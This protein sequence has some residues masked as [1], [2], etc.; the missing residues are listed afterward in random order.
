MDLKRL[1]ELAVEALEAQK[2]VVETEIEAIR[3]ELK[4]AETPSGAGSFSTAVAGRGRRNSAMREAQSERMRKIWAA[5]KAS[6]AKKST[7]PKAKPNRSAVSKAI[8]AAMKA[9][10][11]RRK[12]KAAVSASKAKRA[13]A[14]ALKP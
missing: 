2:A 8:S 12:A 13:S 6:A 9:A 14:K 5:R 3:A 4:D 7:Q 1:L 11:A 10:W